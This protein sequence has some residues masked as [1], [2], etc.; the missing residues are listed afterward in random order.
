MKK[1][2][3]T[4]LILLLS[5]CLFSACGSK[6]ADNATDD[7]QTTSDD[8]NA[9][10]SS[11]EEP[12][13]SP[14][15][16]TDETQAIASASPS[17]SNETQGQKTEEETKTET[18]AQNTT[19]TKKENTSFRTATAKGYLNGFADSHSVEITQ[20]NGKVITYQVK[21]DKV[22]AALSSLEEEEGT[23]FTFTYTEENGSRTIDAI[24]P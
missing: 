22:L 11:L 15:L 8:R 9:P 5:L 17:P 12:S 7:T 18:A 10:V 14:S 16:D 24:N 23:L 21:D 6:D 20:K 2:V 19:E 3:Y 4:S 13:A 1:I